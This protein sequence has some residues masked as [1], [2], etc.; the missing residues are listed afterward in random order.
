MTDLISNRKLI[1]SLLEAQGQ[2]ANLR[3]DT[4]V[5]TVN[6]GNYDNL[7]SPKNDPSVAHVCFHDSSSKVPPGWRGVLVDKLRNTWIQ[8]RA[9]KCLPHILFPNS[10]CSLYVDS[11]FIFRQPAS[12]FISEK[13]VPPFTAFIHPNRKSV[14]EE[15]LECQRCNKRS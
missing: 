7:S 8:S 6:F 15:I 13:C 3:S 2:V 9:F 1:Q 14:H 11:S 10:A 4:I 5:Y 12:I